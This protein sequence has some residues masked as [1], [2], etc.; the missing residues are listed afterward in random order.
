MLGYELDFN[1]CAIRDGFCKSSHISF[2]LHSAS[3]DC[4]AIVKVKN[5]ST[6][7]QE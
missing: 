7:L 3:L 2:L 6:I 1:S 5:F 4:S